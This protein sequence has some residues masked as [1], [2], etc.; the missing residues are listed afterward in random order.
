[1]EEKIL[2]MNQ[3]IN[4]ILIKTHIDQ[5]KI[6]LKIAEHIVKIK[7]IHPIEYMFPLIYWISNYFH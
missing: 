1:M 4:K 7:V 6:V 5:A 3:N 2:F